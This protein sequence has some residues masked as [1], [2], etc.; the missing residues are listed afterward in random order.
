MCLPG[1]PPERSLGVRW[2]FPDHD[3]RPTPRGHP[4][5]RRRRL[6]AP[7]GR[8]RGGNS[9]GS[10]R[11]SPG[12]G[13]PRRAHGGRI[14]KTMGDAVFAEFP[15]IVAA[16]ECAIEMQAMMTKRNA[17]RPETSA[18]SIASG[19]SRRRADRRRRSSRRRGQY[20]G[21]ARGRRR[22][23]RHLPFR[24]RLRPRAREDRGG[25]RRPRRDDA[26]EHRAA[27]RVSTP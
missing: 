20:R 25:F 12:G 22:A 19:S 18:S 26:Q 9:T 13:S 4:R 14:F 5:R 8:G 17:G 1:R 10:A 11:A 2:G 3:G 7:D 24:R 16:V 6:L 23:G 27:G 15:S 21:A